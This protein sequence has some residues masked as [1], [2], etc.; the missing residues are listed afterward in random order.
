[1]TVQGP[2]GTRLL[3][4]CIGTMWYMS[5]QGPYGTWLYRD[6][7]VHICYMAVQGPCGTRLLHGCT[8]TMWYMSVTWLYRDHVVHGCTGT[9]WYSLLHGCTGTL[10]YM[11]VQ[12]PYGTVCYMAVQGPCGTWLY[13]DR[14]VH[15]CYMAVLGPCG[16]MDVRVLCLRILLWW[17]ISKGTMYRTPSG[18]YLKGVLLDQL[19]NTNFCIIFAADKLKAEESARKIRDTIAKGH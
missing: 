11:A 14:M 12:G 2:C 6:H 3:H 16:G 8:G 13:R 18:Q 1:M 5:V 15:V 10:W 17:C 4:G 9:I 19:F 7:V